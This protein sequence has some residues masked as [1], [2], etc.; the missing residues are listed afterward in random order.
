MVNKSRKSETGGGEG[1][2]KGSGGAVETPL[3]M[4]PPLSKE[5]TVRMVRNVGVDT[6][7]LVTPD[8]GAG[9]LED[10]SLA[11]KKGL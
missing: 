9:Y 2:K 7:T 10:L 8:V 4:G 1:A 6:T 5:D 3:K 11:G